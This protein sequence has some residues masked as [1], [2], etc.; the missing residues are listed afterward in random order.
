MSWGPA[1]ILRVWKV[2]PTSA[3]TAHVQTD[4][5]NGYLKGLNNPEGPHLLA[6]ELLG[7]R[8]ARWL[9]LPTFQFAVMQ[10]THDDQLHFT[11]EAAPGLGPAYIT[12]AEAGST[13]GGNDS[14][15]LA[16][17]NPE[18]IAGLVVLDTWIM[19]CD[20]YRVRGD[21]IRDNQ[22]NV[23]FS[24]LDAPKGKFRLV[25]MDHTHAFSCGSE[26]TPAKLCRIEIAKSTEVFGLFPGF[27]PFVTRARV[28]PFAAA[29][30]RFTPRDARAIVA[31]VPRQWGYNDELANALAEFL[32]DRGHFLAGA[33]ME[34]LAASCS[35]NPVLRFGEDDEDG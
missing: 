7:T 19:N 17:E 30:S 10:L 6:C 35:W 21:E 16:V 4:Q 33:L 24:A 8:V 32:L 28:A 29:L 25:A 1:N 18:A 31:D 13:W 20:R 34:I 9:G 12:R 15:L 26:L 11:E 23:F 14:A 5:G 2:H 22:R 27:V 3:R